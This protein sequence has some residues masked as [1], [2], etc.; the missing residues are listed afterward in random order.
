MLT[1]KVDVDID[2]NARATHYEPVEKH[3]EY[4]HFGDTGVA[5]LYQA[6][7]RVFF[8]GEWHWPF[9]E[10]IRTNLSGP[11]SLEQDHLLVSCEE[12][13]IICILAFS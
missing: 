8:T 13:A 4:H 7:H 1:I 3:L 11:Y 6:S 5:P 2:A 9:C 10:R 12:D